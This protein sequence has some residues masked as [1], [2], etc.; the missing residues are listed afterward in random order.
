MK[1]LI[2]E[3]DDAICQTLKLIVQMNAHF[4]EC[5][6]TIKDAKR[7]LTENQYDAI[8]LDLLIQGEMSTD[9]L[10]LKG[11]SKAIV[12]SAWHQAPAIAA[13]Y[14]LDLIK[15]PFDIEELEKKLLTKDTDLN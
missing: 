3:D 1:I 14:S 2:V 5:A 12:L 9:L 11:K 8:C 10:K 7:L 15:K 6:M 13:E 4:A